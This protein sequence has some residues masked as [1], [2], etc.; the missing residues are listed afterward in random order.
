VPQ[1][2]GDRRR[3][4]AAAVTSRGMVGLGVDRGGSGEL[5]AIGEI[6]GV[7]RQVLAEGV[8]RWTAES[9]LFRRLHLVRPTGF[10]AATSL[11]VALRRSIDSRNEL[12]HGQ[13]G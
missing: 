4:G 11:S 5:G 2:A 1:A 7:Y 3:R 6:V 13:A 12:G 8:R 10:E 9:Q